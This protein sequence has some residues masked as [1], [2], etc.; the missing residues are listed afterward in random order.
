MGRG[1]PRR[2]PPR[3]SVRGAKCAP[4]KAG[5]TCSRLFFPETEAAEEGIFIFAEAGAGGQGVEFFAVSTA[6]DDVIGGE[7]IFETLHNF[8]YVAAPL[9]FAEALEAANAEIVLVSFSFFVEQVREFHRL[10]K[11]AYNWEDL[12]RL[13]RNSDKIDPPKIVKQCVS[14]YSFLA[15]LTDEERELAADAR[16]HKRE[17]LWKKLTESCRAKDR[18]GEFGQE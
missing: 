14:C 15:E 10:E 8:G 6:E 7:G 17:E 1:F 5:P 3:K 2:G 12:K 9:F 13:L 4:Q 11:T 16:A 18:P